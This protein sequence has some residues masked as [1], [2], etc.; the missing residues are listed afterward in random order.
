MKQENLQTLLSLVSN[1]MNHVAKEEKAAVAIDEMT[2][3]MDNL[4]HLSRQPLTYEQKSKMYYDTVSAL[5]G[6][7]EDAAKAA[8]MIRLRALCSGDEEL[9][10]K[11]EYLHEVL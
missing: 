1:W 8:F 5:N 9:I 11:I 2:I 7:S 4:A 6:G 10:E 3:M